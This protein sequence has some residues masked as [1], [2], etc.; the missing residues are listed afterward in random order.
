M[1]KSNTGLT[2]IVFELEPS[3]WHDHGTESLWAKLLGDNA[4]Q[5]DNIPFYAYGVSDKDIVFAKKIDN[6]LLFQKV[7]KNGGHSTYRIFQNEDVEGQ[8]FS[9]YW[10]PLEEIGCGKETGG[11]GFFAV[12]VPPETDIYRAY[13]LLEKGEEDEIWQ[14]EEGKCGHELK[15]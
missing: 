11:D 12:D 8:V 6:E 15:E 14:F 2:K 5:I 1:N 4:Y 10:K 3:E 13:A 9:A 7:I